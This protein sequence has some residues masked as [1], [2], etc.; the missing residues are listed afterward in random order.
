MARSIDGVD[1]IL[2]RLQKLPDYLDTTTGENT[3]DTPHNTGWGATSSMFGIVS[4]HYGSGDTKIVSTGDITTSAA[5][6][7]GIVVYYPHGA[8]GEEGSLE[9][10]GKQ[11][12]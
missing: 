7:H 5:G 4:I 1:G 2:D 10:A 6:A 3:E 8:D 11:L 9:D 12:S